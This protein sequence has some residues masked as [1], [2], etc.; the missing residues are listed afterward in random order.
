LKLL[1]NSNLSTQM[2]VT[3]E[4]ILTLIRTSI[5]SVCVAVSAISAGAFMNIASAEQT[6]APTKPGL[7]YRTPFTMAG[8]ED[9]RRHAMKEIDAESSRVLNGRIAE[10]GAWPWQVAL[11][12]EGSKPGYV[13]QFCGGSLIQDTWVLTAAHCVIDSRD[14]GNFLADKDKIVVMVGS[15]TISSEGDF[16]PVE[17]IVA[18][19]GYNPNGFDTDIALIKLTRKPTK[20]FKTITIPTA[21]YADILEQ[22]GVTTIVTGWGRTETGEASPRL[23]EGKIQMLSRDVCNAALMKPRLSLAAEDFV[24]AVNVLGVSGDSANKLWQQL[25]S[26]AALPFTNNMICS[27]TP[28]GPRGAC[29]GDSGGPLVVPVD[30]GNFIQAGIVSWGMFQSDGQGCDRQAKFSA[31]TRAGNFADWVLTELGY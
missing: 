30:G 6:F 1:P 5:L 10:D 8:S 14:D 11:M 9:K 12:R 2:N 21:D 17:K 3:T 13:S 26:E 25:I 22:P 28:E 16:V 27:G 19:P 23:L 7:Y 18:H 15:N 29:D 24:K 20:P 31:Y 4:R